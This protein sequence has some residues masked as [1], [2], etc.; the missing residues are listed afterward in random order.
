MRNVKLSEEVG[1][2]LKD[3]GWTLAVAESCTGGGLSSLITDVAGSSGYFLGGV[4]AYSNRLKTEILSVELGLIEAGGAVSAEVAR[5]MAL[6]VRGTTSAEVGVGLS[7]IAGPG[8]GSRDKPVG[9]VFIAVVT[10]KT[11]LVREYRLSGS[12][13]E[14]REAAVRQAL[15]LLL[16]ALK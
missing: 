15:W 10:P 8:G 11:E 1:L 14:I 9:L 5:E 7:G 16:E 13:R 2:R 4:V 3:L 12:R 6:G